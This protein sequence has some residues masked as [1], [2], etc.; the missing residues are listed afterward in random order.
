MKMRHVAASVAVLILATAPAIA[1]DQVRPS[2]V[3]R[4]ATL[5]CEKE[6]QIRLLVGLTE[7]GMEGD[8]ALETL[9]ESAGREVC[10][11]VVLRQSKMIGGDSFFF[12]EHKFTIETWQIFEMSILFRGQWFRVIRPVT[13]YRGFAED[14]PHT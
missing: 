7:N 12:G 3:I 11:P 14:A 13:W 6:Y 2:V 9:N 10:N 8:A 1:Q 5:F 4:H